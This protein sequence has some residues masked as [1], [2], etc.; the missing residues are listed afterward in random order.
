MRT[1][2]YLSFE[3]CSG[4][5]DLVI[6]VRDDGAHGHRFA[7]ADERFVSLVAKDVAKVGEGSF[8]L[9]N[10]GGGGGDDA[11]ETGDCG[12][13]FVMSRSRSG[14]DCIHN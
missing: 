11:R 4:L 7:L 6:A 12:R 10:R 14:S 3:F 1:P 13:R 2:S 8:E 5:V 9:R